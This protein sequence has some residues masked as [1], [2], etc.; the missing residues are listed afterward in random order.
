MHL[1]SHAQEMISQHNS[2]ETLDNKASSTK[3]ILSKFHSL[4]EQHWILVYYVF[5][6]ESQKNAID[7]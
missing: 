1:E 4:F 3:L 5:P 2:G 6:L 7:F